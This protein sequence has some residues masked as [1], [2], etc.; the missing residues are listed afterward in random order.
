MIKTFRI[1]IYQLWR[2]CL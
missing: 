2:F 1:Y